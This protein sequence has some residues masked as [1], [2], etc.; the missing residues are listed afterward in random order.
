[1]VGEQRPCSSRS[2][3]A[4]APPH[5]QARPGDQGPRETHGDNVDYDLEGCAHS[6]PSPACLHGSYLRWVG[7]ERVAFVAC[8]IGRG[9]PIWQRLGPPPARFQH[10]GVD[11]ILSPLHLAFCAPSTAASRRP[12]S[13]RIRRRSDGQSA[14]AAP[15]QRKESSTSRPPAA[16]QGRPRCIPSA[17]S[18]HVRCTSPGCV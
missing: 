11:S 17:S 1:M 8:R 5:R 4:L 16:I 14:P 7:S 13:R 10:S 2:A 6:P 9:R 18:V 12:R 15:P 3:L